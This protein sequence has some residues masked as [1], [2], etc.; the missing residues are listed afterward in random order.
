MKYTKWSI[1]ER[2]CREG[3]GANER[4]TVAFEAWN[5]IYYGDKSNYKWKSEIKVIEEK[6][7]FEVAIELNFAMEVSNRVW[8]RETTAKVAHKTKWVVISSET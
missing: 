2:S 5:W 1:N 3:S 6:S 8:M 7:T 4:K